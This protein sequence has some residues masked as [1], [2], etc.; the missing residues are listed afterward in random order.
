MTIPFNVTLRRMQLNENSPSLS[1][2]NPQCPLWPSVLLVSVW[3][4]HIC[5]TSAC[6]CITPRFSIPVCSTVCFQ[7]REQSK[8]QDSELLPNDSDLTFTFG[9]TP[10]TAKEASR[11]ADAHLGWSTNGRRIGSTSEEREL[12][13]HEQE[14]LSRGTRLVFPIEDQNWTASF[15]PP[16]PT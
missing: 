9:D 6:M 2:V 10:I 16:L 3:S 13:S 12:D 14:L 1:S 7:N 8:D 11:S 5:P 15:F 4:H